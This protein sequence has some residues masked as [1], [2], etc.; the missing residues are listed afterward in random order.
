[1]RGDGCTLRV[2][3]PDGTEALTAEGN[4]AA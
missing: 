4:F 1:L 3:A 2:S